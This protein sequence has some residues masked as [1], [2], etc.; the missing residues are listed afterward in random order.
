MAWNYHDDDLPG[1][2]MRRRAD[3][4]RNPGAAKRVAGAALPHRSGAQQRLDGVE[5][6]GIAAEPDGGTVRRLE[7]AGQLQLLESPSWV[8]PDGGKVNLKFALPRQGVSLV[9]LSW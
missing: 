7:A 2:R 8:W 4:L 1:A 3:N 5:A 6:D 9:Q